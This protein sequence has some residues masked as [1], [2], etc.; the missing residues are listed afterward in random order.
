M[1]FKRQGTGLVPTADALAL[2]EQIQP[3]FQSLE[4][5]KGFE[6]TQPKSAHLRI[7]CPP[8]VAQCFLESIT[9]AF[10]RDNP[11][12]LVSMDIVTTPEVLELVA[13]QRADI[14]F[15]DVPVGNTG[16]TRS[17]FRRSRMVCVLPQA[18]PLCASEHIEVRGL[19]K[20]AMVM[21]AK[22]NPVRP[23]LDRLFSQAAI[24]PRVVVETATALSAVNYVSQGVGITL[25]NPFPVLLAPFCGVSVRAFAADV[26]YETS[27]FT[28]S[29]AVPNAIAQRYMEYVR[30]HQPQA[31]AHST[32]I[33]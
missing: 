28:S 27:F 11:D 10:L 14:G 4:Q 8:T 12:T 18:H 19:H 33:R 3:I 16:L 7:A 22:R 29:T 13:D 9:A 24:Q 30:E 2:Y 26:D 20:E 5:L 31:M 23:V 21:L 1:L 25:V 6:W 15:A 17:P 32:P